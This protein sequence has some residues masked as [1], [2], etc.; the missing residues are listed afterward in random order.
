MFED[1][2]YHGGKFENVEISKKLAIPN[3]IDLILKPNILNNR[4]NIILVNNEH[5][6]SLIQILIQQNTHQLFL[7]LNFNQKTK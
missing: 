2:L 1:I 7:I 6:L 4:N 5:H 3:L